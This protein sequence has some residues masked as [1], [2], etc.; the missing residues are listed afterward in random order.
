MKIY[1]FILL[2]VTIIFLIY[3]NIKESFDEKILL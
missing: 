2:F 3:N 1:I